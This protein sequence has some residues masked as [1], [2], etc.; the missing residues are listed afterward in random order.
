MS[1]Y[2][3]LLV[4][5]PGWQVFCELRLDSFAFNAASEEVFR[6]L[7]RWIVAEGAADGTVTDMGSLLSATTKLVAWETLEMDRTNLATNTGW[8]QAS[9]A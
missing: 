9:S 6:E 5:Q 3:A 1:Q 8:F 7:R 2:P 4:Q